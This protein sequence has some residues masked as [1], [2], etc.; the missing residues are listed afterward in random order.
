MHGSA[1]K[2]VV[3]HDGNTPVFEPMGVF[4]SC[5]T[6]PLPALPTV[7]W[8][9]TSVP[10]IRNMFNAIAGSLSL[11]AIAGNSRMH[12]VYRTTVAYGSTLAEC[13]VA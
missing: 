8:S 2:G 13:N 9:G 11:K 4:P 6:T 5:N 10:E 7:G 12:Y 3:L 1:G